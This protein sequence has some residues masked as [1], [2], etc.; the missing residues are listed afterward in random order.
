V[1]LRVALK[2]R[3]TAQLQPPNAV[4]CHTVPFQ[5]FAIVCNGILPPKQHPRQH[6]SYAARQAVDGYADEAGQNGTG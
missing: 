3:P 1:R 4:Q 6:P 5:R 2:Y